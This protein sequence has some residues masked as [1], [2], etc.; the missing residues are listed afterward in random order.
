MNL[1]KPVTEVIR[2]R[3]SCRSYDGRPLDEHSRKELEEFLSCAEDGPFGVPV[4]LH[5]VD[6]SASSPWRTRAF[7][8]YGFVSGAKQFLVGAVL[9]ADKDLET[10]G[11]IFEKA[12]LFATELG[13]GTCWIGGT[14][15]RSSFAREIA[16][17]ENETLPA[18][19][20]VGHK[21]TKQGALDSMIH[22]AVGSANRKPWRDLFFYKN[23]DTPISE[24]NA[25]QYSVPLEM[26][27]L[28]PSSVN[29]QPWRIIKIE[30]VNSFHFY[31]KRMGM[32][33][34]TADM[35]TPLDMQ[36]L[37]IGIAM[38]HFDLTAQEMNL[39]GKWEILNPNLCPLPKEM[40]YVV[41]WVEEPPV[42]TSDQ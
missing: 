8:T 22:R 39:K 10:Y 26:V 32:G 35:C 28:A 40:E 4:R 9:Q 41:S 17:R 5:L 21:R 29:A 19:S 37:D 30:G 25:G 27:R 38:C 42:E 15:N 1:K 12:V 3:C 16:L 6:R 13:L 33:K 18:I 20:P 34:R 24:A 23:F 7:G 2:E 31:L 14:F 11:Y 36:R